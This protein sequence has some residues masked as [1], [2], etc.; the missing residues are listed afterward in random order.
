M[1]PWLMR[2]KIKNRS[3]RYGVNSHRSR[4]RQKYTKYKMCI[5]IMKV[6]YTNQHVSNIWSSI[7]EKKLS[8]A[9][10]DSKVLLI[11]KVFKCKG[12]FFKLKSGEQPVTSI[13]IA[14]SNI[15]LLWFREN[16]FQEL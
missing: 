3:E 10:S 2:L 5:S 14:F 1:T 6:I 7:L 8:N 13:K 16:Y 15:P 11:K 12:T 9:E 4:H